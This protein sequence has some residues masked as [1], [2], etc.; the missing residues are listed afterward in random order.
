MKA[1]LNVLRSVLLIPIILAIDAL[2]YWLFRVTII[3]AFL[4]V[5]NFINQFSW[6]MMI[7]ECLFGL[8]LAVPVL[9]MADGLF[10]YGAL[11]AIRFATAISP[12]QIY[13]IWVVIITSGLTGLALLFDIWVSPI[14]YTAWAIFACIV[15]SFVIIGLVRA[16]IS[17]A[18]VQLTEE[19][20]TS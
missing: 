3:A 20:K 14:V 18:L 6:Y 15:I 7:I 5:F 2:I 12:H 19:P 11:N 10:K 16:M 1:I 9:S 17:G 8:L 13:A 4:W